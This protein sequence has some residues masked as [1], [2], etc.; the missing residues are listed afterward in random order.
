MKGLIAVIILISCLCMALS[1]PLS[2][3]NYIGA[4]GFL[5]SC[6]VI[7]NKIDERSV[8]NG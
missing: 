6:V 3:S 8:N 1:M 7:G 4:I 2:F 5:C